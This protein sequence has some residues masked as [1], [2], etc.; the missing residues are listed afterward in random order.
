MKSSLGFH[1]L[2][3]SLQLSKQK[4]FNL[5]RD[6]SEYSDKT[7]KIKIYRSDRGIEIVFIHRDMGIRWCITP[8]GN[9]ENSTDILYVEINPKV[10][11]R[12]VDYITASN[13]GDM[14]VAIP[15]FD[16]ISKEIS[17]ILQTFACYTVSRVDYCVNFC[18]DELVPDCSAQQIMNLI[19]RSNIPFNYDEWKEYDHVAHRMK[20]VESSFYL[21]SEYTN[22]N[23]YLKHEELLDRTQ[24]NIAHGYEPVPE[25]MMEASKSIIR[26]EVQCKRRKIYEII[27][28]LGV[29]DDEINK[30]HYLLNPQVCKEIISYYY[31]KVVG[32]GKWYSFAKAIKI[33]DFHDFN[34]QK[35]NRLV[36]TLRTA[37]RRRSVH[38]SKES[39]PKDELGAFT[40]TLKELSNLGIN[41]VTIPQAWGI[42]QIP[43]LL[44]EYNFKEYD[45]DQLSVFS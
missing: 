28:K 17:P 4:S 36:E 40:R 45:I 32:E 43:N 16:R 2:E 31:F 25:R 15:N 44:T 6:F 9:F 33:I 24:K 14:N 18:I 8:K 13:Y 3:L 1:T 27:K 26:F 37:N 41:P 5:G 35:R 21:M 30:Y 20:S 23:C 10:L 19:K 38:K 39:R 11:G 12:D 42:K 7:G 34:S 22:I 29:K